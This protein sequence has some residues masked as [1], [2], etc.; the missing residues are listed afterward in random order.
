M[1]FQDAIAGQMPVLLFDAWRISVGELIRAKLSVY[2][3]FLV[4]K[5]RYHECDTITRCYLLTNAFE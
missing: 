4:D 5:P 3:L 2:L 1:A